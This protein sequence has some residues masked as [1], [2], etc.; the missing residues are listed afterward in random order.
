M[1]KAGEFINFVGAIKWIVLMEA[2]CFFGS[3]S[4]HV[5]S[6]LVQEGRIV[7]HVRIGRADLQHVLKG[8]KFLLAPIGKVGELLLVK[9]SFLPFRLK[10]LLLL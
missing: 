10:H 6:G 5:S 2:E 3:S 9:R 1:G 7:S 4:H 8:L